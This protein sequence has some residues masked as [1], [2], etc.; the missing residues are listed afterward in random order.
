MAE[1]PERSAGAQMRRGLWRAC[2]PKFEPLGS[3][4]WEGYV[5]R[6]FLKCYM[7]ICRLH[8]GALWHR[9]SRS[10]VSG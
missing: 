5:P 3:Q 10:T 1:G 4:T 8:F 6:N 7:Q 9:L 2:P